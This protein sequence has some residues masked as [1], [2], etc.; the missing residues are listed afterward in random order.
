VSLSAFQ[1]AAR[2]LRAGID[3]LTGGDYWNDE[4]ELS[5]NMFS[6]AAEA[7]L[8]NQDVDRVSDLVGS[9]GSCRG[10]MRLACNVKDNLRAYVAK[11]NSQVNDATWRQQLASGLT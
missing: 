1:D 6:A 4:Y 2:F 10:S 11:I 3:F 9:V 7:E 5:L 8:C